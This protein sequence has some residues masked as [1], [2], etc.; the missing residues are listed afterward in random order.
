MKTYSKENLLSEINSIRLEIGHDIDEIHINDVFYDDN[1][2]EL[3]I[4]AEDRVD[5]SS[6][7]GKGGWVVGKLKE[8]LNINKIHVESYGDFL[9]KKYKL[10]LSRKTLIDYENKSIGIKFLRLM[11]DEKIEKLY[12]FDLYRYMV[13]H[14]FEESDNHDAIVALSGGI[15]SSFSLIIAK[16]LGFNP[17]AVSVDPGSIILPNQFKQNINNLVEKLETPHKYIKTDFSKIIEK[18]LNGEIHPCGRCSNKIEEKITTFA[19]KSNIPIVIYGDMLSTGRGCITG[20]DIIRLNL[21]ASLS[22]GKEEIKAI[23]RKYSIN[24]FKNYGCPLLHETQRKYP[25]L[26]KFSIQRI[27]RETHSQAL[28]TGEALKLIWSLKI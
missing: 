20:Q 2:D 7:I 11:V 21:P 25:H 8:R 6:I 16:K 15:D 13:E 4:I 12:K 10:E 24:E 1:V 18:S 26:K 9:V 17:I 23:T 28:E 3:W 5:K 27:L 19:K 22:M 14:E